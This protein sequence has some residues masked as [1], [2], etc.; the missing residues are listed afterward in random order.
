MALMKKMSRR[1]RIRL[2]SFLLTTIIVL[3]G[4]AL[5]GF[6]LAAKYRM[7]LEYGYEQSLNQLSEHLNNLEITLTKGIY[8]GTPQGRFCDKSVERSGFGKNLPCGFAH[9]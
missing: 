2:W 6:S 3:G 9:L 5:T 8:S 4:F 1:G 7:R